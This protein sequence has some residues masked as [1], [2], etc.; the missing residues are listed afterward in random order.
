[1][2]K[3][4]IEQKGFFHNQSAISE[5]DHNDHFVKGLG[6]VVRKDQIKLFVT[7]KKLHS[8]PPLE[9]HTDSA[10]ADFITWFCEDPGEQPTPTRYLDTKPIFEKFNDEERSLLTQAFMKCPA[11]DGTQNHTVEPL[12]TI[13][14]QKNKIFYTPWWFITP[15]NP[16]IAELIEQFKS[17]VAQGSK[18]DAIEITLKKGETIII[19]N[20][21]FLHGRSALPENTSRYLKRTWISAL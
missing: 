12:L 15:E 21:R 13:E 20:K 9:F 17:H 1:M 10:K 18:E 2:V 8:T 16:K 5:Q 14:N 3:K 11:R 19:D 4:E 6:S 7:K